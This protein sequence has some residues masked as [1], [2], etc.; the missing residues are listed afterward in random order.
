[1]R[2]VTRA[3]FPPGH[4]NRPPTDEKYLADIEAATLDQLKAFHAANYGPVA[5]RLVAVGDV[6]GAAIDRTLTEAFAGWQ[7]GRAI[8]PAQKAPAIAKG[9]TEKVNMP[10]KTSISFVLGEPSGLR[11]ADRDYQPLNMATSVFG[12]GFFS[13]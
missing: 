3:I 9:R 7:G 4:P 8:P 2:H 10:G 5:A 11:Y 13:A 6:D 1:R 12:S